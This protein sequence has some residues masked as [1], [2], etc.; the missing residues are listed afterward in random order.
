MNNF[1]I[2]LMEQNEE[3]QSI[4]IHYPKIN[5]NSFQPVRHLKNNYVHS[6][7]NPLINHFTLSSFFIF[8]QSDSLKYFH[9]L[10][11]KN[12]LKLNQDELN[13]LKS[14]NND[15]QLQKYLNDNAEFISIDKNM[16]DKIYDYFEIEKSPSELVLYLQRKIKNTK[17]RTKLSCRKLAKQYFD[18]T[19]KKAGKSTIHKTLKNHMGLYYLKT[20]LKNK[21]LTE[22]LGILYSLSFIKIFVRAIKLGFTPIFIDETKIEL[23]NNHFKVWR[24]RKEQIY[25]GKSSKEKTNMILAVG[26]N[27]IYSYK[28]ID[29]N[30][31]SNIFIDFLKEL[32]ETINTI[33]ETKYVLILDNLKAHKTEDVFKFLKINNICAVFNAPYMSIFNSIELSFRSIKK[34]VYSNLY[35]SLE[36]VKAD[37]IKYLKSDDI[38]RTLSYN[39]KETVSQYISYSEKNACLNLNN[40]KIIDDE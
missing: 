30:V 1:I 5:D 20:T 40:L 31:N 6:I 27:K 21:F 19:G 3:S 33:K 34:I 11:N 7:N 28:I 18:E 14:M 24:F 37:V 9:S 36:D 15:I 4:Q 23:K 32:I 12:H 22:D 13:F 16:Y 26:Q 17:D 25:F 38:I 35:D 10:N 8:G 39:Y 2:L 29:Q